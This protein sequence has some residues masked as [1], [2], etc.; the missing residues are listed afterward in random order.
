MGVMGDL[1]GVAG[2][3]KGFSA[4]LKVQVASGVW[5]ASG[6]PI[7]GGGESQVSLG[8]RRWPW[9]LAG[10]HGGPPLATEGPIFMMS[11]TFTLRIIFTVSP[12]F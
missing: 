1:G 2:G 10:C 8:G 7:V 9:G 3:L 11:V 6:M 12:F 4:T 5:V